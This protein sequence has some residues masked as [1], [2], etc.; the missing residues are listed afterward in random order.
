MRF[1][2]IEE[3]E[4]DKVRY[5]SSEATAVRKHAAELSKVLG[6]HLSEPYPQDTWG[7]SFTPSEDG[8]SAAIDTPFG[9]ARAVVAVGLIE[10]SIQARYIFEKLVTKDTGVPLY[11]VVWAVLVRQ[12]GLVLT[13]DGE[14]RILSLHDH[15][16]LKRGNGITTIALSLIYAIANDPGYAVADAITNS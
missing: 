2:K 6:E 10:G 15:S 8:L 5:A 3:G 16:P 11:R 7:I 1:S 9:S 12:D 13:D 4:F 14:S